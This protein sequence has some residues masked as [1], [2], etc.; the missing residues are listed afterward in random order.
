[1]FAT[2]RDS[3]SRSVER[4]EGSPTLQ[5]KPPIWMSAYPPEPR[6]NRK[7]GKVKDGGG[8]M[9]NRDGED[10]RDYVMASGVEVN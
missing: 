1:M 7:D 5:V 9:V 3:F 4:P 8:E 10:Q 2:S 6:G